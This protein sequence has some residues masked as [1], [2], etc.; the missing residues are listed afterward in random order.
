MLKRILIIAG[1]RPEIIKL[2]PVVL[3]AEAQFKKHVHIDLC[4]TGQHQTMAQEAMSIFGLMP[5]DNLEIMKPD[6]SLNDIS[7]TVFERLPAIIQRRTPDVLMVQGD[8][9]T[10]AMAALCSFNMRVPVAHVEAGL[11]SYN[12]DA[13]YPEELN[14]KVISCLAAYNFCP[15]DSSKA[16][17][18]N[19][20]IAEPT[21]HVTGNTVVD[22]L[23][24]LMR[25]QQLDRWNSIAPALQQPF[26]LIT[27]HRRES[28]GDGFRNICEAIKEVALEF[29][30]Y[31]FVYPVHLNPNVVRPVHALLGNIHNVHLI[32]PQPYLELV[33]LLKNCEFVLTDSGGIQEEAPSLGKYAIVMR[34]VTERMASVHRGFSQLVGADKK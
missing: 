16:N 17:L 28:F 25:T 11:R 20:G 12:L 7:A 21:L 34:D 15:T 26:V 23:F 6:Q 4:I 24:Y 3:T 13:P 31:H 10:A 27:A 33:M 8:T 18:V 2:A 14:R 1:T 19:E 9:T 30:R 32:S 5:V 29:P 22:A